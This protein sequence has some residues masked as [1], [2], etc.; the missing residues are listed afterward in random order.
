MTRWPHAASVPRVFLAIVCRLHSLALQETSWWTASRPAPTLEIIWAL[1]PLRMLPW[2]CSGLHTALRPGRSAS[3]TACASR[4]P[5][6]SAWAAPLRRC[7]GTATSFLYYTSYRSQW[8]KCMQFKL[9]LRCNDWPGCPAGIIHSHGVSGCCWNT[10]DHVIVLGQALR[11]AA[12][13]AM[14]WSLL[15]LADLCS[16]P[17]CLGI[18]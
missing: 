2:A 7:G 13:P 16:I 12:H 14:R 4:S 8:I 18:A 6:S 1:S 10:S 5:C 11:P 17:A 15:Q 9:E 3:C